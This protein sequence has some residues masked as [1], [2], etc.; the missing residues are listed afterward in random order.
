MKFRNSYFVII[1]LFCFGFFNP[2]KVFAA[3]PGIYMP[4]DSGNEEYIK[5]NYAKALTYYLKFINSGIQS[6]Q[7]YY[8]IGN[9]YYKTNEIPKAILFY[10]KAEKLAP[11]DADVKFNLQLANQKIT[12]RLPAEAPM[13]L[14]SNWRKFVNKFTEKQWSLICIWLLCSSLF[15]FGLYLYFSQLFIKQLSF[16]AA[17]SVLVLC[18]FTFYLA[19]KQ[20]DSLNSHDT[21]IVMS[22]TVTV[23][24]APEDKAT[25]LFVIHEGTKVTIV[26]NEGEWTEVKLPN[27][28][29]GWLISTDINAI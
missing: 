28:N 12:D 9:C 3:A 13:F 6:A 2:A 25:A 17:C 18:L 27:G 8:N 23:K 29:Q 24:G 21:A 4:M 5:G 7:A 22:A 14:Y 10:E 20:Y 11:D 15:L 19:T 26:K 16:W 1:L